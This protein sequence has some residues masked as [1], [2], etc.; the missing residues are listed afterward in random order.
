MGLSVRGFSP[1]ER[2][3]SLSGEAALLSDQDFLQ[4]NG[5]PPA[6]ISVQITGMPPKGKG[7]IVTAAV[8]LLIALGGIVQ[9]AKREPHTRGASNADRKSAQ[10]LILDELVR[11]EQAL[12]SGAIGPETHSRTKRLLLDALARLDGESPADPAR[13]KAA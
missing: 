8:A 10:V 4:P 9:A 2:T 11:L 7:N 12:K 13:P 6:E 1:A 3:R 5:H